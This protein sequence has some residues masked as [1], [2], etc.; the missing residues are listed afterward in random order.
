MA[1]DPRVHDEL[2]LAVTHARKLVSKSDDIQAADLMTWL[3]RFDYARGAY[4]FAESIWRHECKL[5]RIILGLEHPS[6]LTSMNNLA[7]TLRAQ[8]DI[9]GA[10]NI[11][12]QVFEGKDRP[13]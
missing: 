13:E 4:N 5:R 3:G 8:G 1:G 12:E 10:R 11:Q 9:E 6:T 2:R 7:V